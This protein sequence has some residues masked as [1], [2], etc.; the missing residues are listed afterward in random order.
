MPIVAPKQPESLRYAVVR[1]GCCATTRCGRVLFAASAS[2]LAAQLFLGVALA[3]QTATTPAPA[4]AHPTTHSAAPPSAHPAAHPIAHRATHS[5][6]HAHRKPSAAKPAAQAAPAPAPA[7]PQIPNWPANNKP[8][9]ATVVWDSHGLLIQAS[10]SS[11]DQILN[12]VSLKTGAKVE[13]EGEDER[14]FGTYGPGPARDVLNELLDGSGYNILMVGDQGAGTPRRIVLSGR[15]AKL[16]QPAGNAHP[17]AS[18]DDNDAENDQDSEPNP[19]EQT[20]PPEGGAAPGM[21]MR[22]PQQILE[23][24]QQRLQQMQQQQQNNSQDSQN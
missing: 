21:P 1:R 6:S 13:G 7:A 10:N 4:A 14:I 20:P 19:P 22:T 9:A 18:N 17:V 15:P 8:S 11:L 23:E 3:A 5:P 24:R 12:D 16:A 2:F